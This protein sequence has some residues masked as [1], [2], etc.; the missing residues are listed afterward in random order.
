MSD[1]KNARRPTTVEEAL[2]S[3]PI[4]SMKGNE[5]PRVPAWIRRL[6]DR[7]RPNRGRRRASN[8]GDH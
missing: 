8:R 2:V 5:E 4:V 3:R 6:A 7:I 1:P